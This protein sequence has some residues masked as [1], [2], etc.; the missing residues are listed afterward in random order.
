MNKAKVKSDI[1]TN[2]SSK[3]LVVPKGQS[4]CIHS[5]FVVLATTAT[6]GARNMRLSILDDDDNVLYSVDAL[7]TQAASLTYK[8]AFLPG[9]ANEDHA[10]KLWFQAGLPQ[11]CVLPTGYQIKI[12]DSAAIDAAADDM[13]VKA[14]YVPSYSSL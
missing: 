3:T 13:T 6:V 2:D 7:A 4:W 11:D 9:A 10:A 12:E 1:L 14:M 8:Y 5:I